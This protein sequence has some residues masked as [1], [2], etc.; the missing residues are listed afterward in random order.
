MESI[1]AIVEN[2]AQKVKAPE[3]HQVTQASMPPDPYEEARISEELYRELQQEKA[4]GQAIAKEVIGAELEEAEQEIGF[5]ARLLVQATLPHSKPKPDPKTGI[6]PNEFKRSN[7]YV[8][9]HIQAPAEYGLPYG[10]YPRLLMVWVT[11][12]AARTKSP[13]LELGDSLNQ[14]MLKLGLNNLYEPKS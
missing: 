13:E 14:F 1:K 3:L 10:T 9:V 6:A 8:T 4:K 2:S 5:S 11:T 12:E 7:G